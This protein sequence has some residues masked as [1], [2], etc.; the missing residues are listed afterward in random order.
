MTAFVGDEEEFGNECAS[1]SSTCARSVGEQGRSG[2]FDAASA[3]Y[4]KGQA[5]DQGGWLQRQ[6][7]SHSCSIA[8]DQPFDPCRGPSGNERRRWRKK[9]SMI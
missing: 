1:L 7:K 9:A 3:N 6:E 2:G 4:E 5:A 8:V